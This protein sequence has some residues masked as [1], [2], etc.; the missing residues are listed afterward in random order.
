MQRRDI[1]AVALVV[2]DA[3]VLK[4]GRPR[5]GE[6]GRHLAAP[7]AW[8]QE[9]GTD[10][11]IG[12]IAAAAAWLVAVWLGVGLLAATVARLPGGCGR[13]G[14][15]VSRRLLPRAM[16]QVVAG[17]VGLG[18][19]LAPVAAGAAPR[20]VPHR[21]AAHAT[22]PAPGWPLDPAPARSTT[23]PRR[24][25]TPATPGRACLPPPSWPSNAAP[26]PTSQPTPHPTTQPTRPAEHP[27][28]GRGLRVRAGDSLWLIT[29]R[30]LG[31]AATP[32]EIAAQW[33]QW[34]A[35]NRDVI[36]RDPAL[37]MPGQLLHTPLKEGRR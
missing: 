33:P 19:L 4:L 28:A 24:D 25:A 34:Y 12:S 37:I 1:A 6:L 20:P 36:G 15:F 30:R 35:A 11:A 22:L 31:P 14:A 7:R 10:A 5:F 2:S 32:A 8:L 13:A 27:R 26:R 3:A 18:V 16:L 29:A 17:S 23:P 9:A 21:V